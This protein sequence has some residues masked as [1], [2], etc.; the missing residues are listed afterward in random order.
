MIFKVLSIS[1]SL[2]L[3]VFISLYLILQLD[4][5]VTSETEFQMKF[6]EIEREFDPG[7]G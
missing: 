1:K 3:F 6:M 2:D 5:Y 7:S 4:K